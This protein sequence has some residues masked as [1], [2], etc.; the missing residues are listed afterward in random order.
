MALRLQAY[1]EHLLGVSSLIPH[2]VRALYDASQKCT[3]FGT[4]QGA[5]KNGGFYHPCDWLLYDF[6]PMWNVRKPRGRGTGQTEL[7]GKF[8]KEL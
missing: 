3:D 5:L 7:R 8:V 6:L 1:R 4:V 2:C